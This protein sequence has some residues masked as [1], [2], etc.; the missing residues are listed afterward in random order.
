MEFVFYLVELGPL[1][2]LLVFN[3]RF[4]RWLEVP[5]KSQRD[6]A[7]AVRS[8]LAWLFSHADRLDEIQGGATFDAP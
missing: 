1:T 7:A 4:R 3:R 8:D 6:F 2:V 5:E